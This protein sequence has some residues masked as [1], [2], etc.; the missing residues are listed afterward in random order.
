MPNNT[1]SEQDRKGQDKKSNFD[2]TM[3][4]DTVVVPPN[5]EHA[6]KEISNPSI[7]RKTINQFFRTDSPSCNKPNLY[8]SGLGGFRRNLYEKGVSVK[9]SIL[10]S[11]SMRQSY[12]SGLGKSGPAVTIEG[13]LIHFDVLQG[14]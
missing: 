7:I 8:I 10:I 13:R 2:N 3:L 12:L 5:I 4:T 6:D 9:A 1:S 14:Q 11:N